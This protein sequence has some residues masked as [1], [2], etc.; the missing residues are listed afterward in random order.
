M[1]SHFIAFAA[2]GAFVYLCPK[3]AERAA[4][5]FRWLRRWW[6]SVRR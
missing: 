1:I 2:G 6:G 3:V 4:A 5:V